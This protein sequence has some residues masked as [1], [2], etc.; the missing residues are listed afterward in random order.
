MV[1]V[2]GNPRPSE[3]E[4]QDSLVKLDLR[5]AE[6]DR[7][8]GSN[9]DWSV[10]SEDGDLEFVTGFHRIFEHNPIGHI[11]T[12]DCARTRP[13]QRAGHLSV[14]P[15]LGIIINEYTKYNHCAGRVETTYTRRDRQIRAIPREKNFAA[16]AAYSK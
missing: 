15:D 8:Q 10:D 12:L 14:D 11:K 7:V 6:P 4:H 5:L 9:R 2:V 16:S 1:T 3:L 13:A